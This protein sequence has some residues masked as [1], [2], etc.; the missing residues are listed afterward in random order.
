MASS[1]FITAVPNQAVNKSNKREYQDEINEL[2]A[3]VSGVTQRS[4]STLLLKKK[5]EMREVSEALA[6]MK[7]Q[8]LE[9][10][11]ACDENHLTFERRQMDMKEQV[12]KFEKFIQ[13]NDAKRQRAEMRAK[14]ERRKG[15]AKTEE[16]RLLKL[17]LKEAE[18][19][20]EKLQDEL[21]RLNRYKE[22]LD[23]T[24]EKAPDNELEQIE[25]ILNRLKT[26]EDAN[27][28]LQYQVEGNDKNMDDIRNELQVFR[29]EMQNQ[30]LVQN[31][32]VHKYQNEL[33]RLK[34]MSKLGRDDEEARQV[35][36]NDVNR[37][38]GQIIM[39][40]RNLYTRC[41]NTQK[42]KKKPFHN[43]W[44]NN[45]K[46]LDWCLSVIRDRLVDLNDVKEQF[47]EKLVKET[48]LPPIPGAKVSV[49]GVGGEKSKGSG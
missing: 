12:I 6:F 4:Q 10:M 25:D 36:D 32:Q 21:N 49:G 26:L 48:E 47:K 45:A 1:A 8:Y 18:I 28:D 43:N 2:E 19:E 15:E 13:E 7:Q 37:E 20:R 41:T 42:S 44:V 35:R 40:I 23:D 9:R 29:L 11:K 30:V 16:I 27:L 14:D 31:S 22:Y 3:L 33:E 39:A 38:T 46:K 24:V 5:K 17:E 34:A